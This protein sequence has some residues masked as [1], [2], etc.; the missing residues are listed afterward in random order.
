MKTI[1]G[2]AKNHR[3]ASYLIIIFGCTFLN[4]SAGIVGVWLEME[5]FYISEIIPYFLLLC[6]L[7]VWF[8]YPK[9]QDY[10][11]HYY[12]RKTA[13]FFSFLITILLSMCFYNQHSAIVST[14]EIAQV[15]ELQEFN[16]RV[17][18]NSVFRKVGLQP[19]S[20]PNSYEKETLKSITVANSAKI[21]KGSKKDQ[22]RKKV[23]KIIKS[24]IEEIKKKNKELNK[25]DRV[26]L[27]IL[28]LLLAIIGYMLVMLIVSAA[29]C[30]LACGGANAIAVLVGLGGYVFATIGLVRL[31]KR[32]FRKKQKPKVVEPTDKVPIEPTP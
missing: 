12:Q 11:N 2:W 29:A 13:D 4:T 25:Q 21:D 32:I 3:I 28:L 24:F 8:F 27:K 19:T 1:S 5:H 26:F 22:Y 14:Q 30:S 18:N 17:E 16:S 15:L 9:K 23:V 10:Y 6:W 20:T 31:I 7:P